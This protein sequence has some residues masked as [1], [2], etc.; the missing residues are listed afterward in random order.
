MANFIQITGSIDLIKVLL[1]TLV[2]PVC[3]F[4]NAY[5]FEDLDDAGMIRVMTEHVP[6]ANYE[7]F[8]TSLYYRLQDPLYKGLKCNIVLPEPSNNVFR[9][10][11]SKK[12]AS[13]MAEDFFIYNG[14][15]NFLELI[16]PLAAD[17]S[18][19]KVELIAIGLDE[20]QMIKLNKQAKTT[21]VAKKINT[22]I[23]KVGDIVQ[24]T[25]RIMANDVVNPLAIAAAKTTAVVGAGL[26]KTAV[27]CALAASNEILRDAA[28]FSMSE[29]KQRDEVQ[30]IAYSIKKIMNKTNEATSKQQTNNYS[31]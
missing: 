9:L 22:K 15:E 14:I 21:V 3:A 20:A 29:L 25:G 28:C 19:N 23:T 12:Q 13:K 31:L 11:S 1:E 16:Y 18:I 10:T 27:D 30:T 2:K 6:A 17:L 7:V 26:A 8:M 5:E 24:S 4:E